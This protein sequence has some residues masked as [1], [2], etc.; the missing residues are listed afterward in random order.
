MCSPLPDSFQWDGDRNSY[1][2][3]DLRTAEEPVPSFLE[4]SSGVCVTVEKPHIQQ[5]IWVVG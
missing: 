5:S 1:I 3:G 4:Y 2:L